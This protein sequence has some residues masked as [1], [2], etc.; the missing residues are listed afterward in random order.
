MSLDLWIGILIAL[1]PSFLL[2]V[3]LAGAKGSMWIAF[4]IGAIGWT[5]AG[6]LRAPIL[7]G[8][9]VA[10]DTAIAQSLPFFVLSS[11]FAG[12]FED[13]IKYGLMKKIERVRADCR[14]VLSLG[15]GWGFV[16]AVQIYALGVLAMV[17]IQGSQLTIL[18]LL[19]GALERNM[20]VVL[21]AS[22]SFIVFKALSDFRYLGLAMVLHAL[23][24]LVAVV[25]HWILGPMRT[26]SLRAF[27]LAGRRT[28]VSDQQVLDIANEFWR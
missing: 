1:T 24:D 28:D 7:S 19:P 16:E 8:I 13:G 4:V 17:Y 5:I 21:H 11:A 25:S 2:F 14:H 12:L 22:F 18:D 20:A 3:Y 10:F 26:G 23:V 6:F 9:L 27:R 15:L